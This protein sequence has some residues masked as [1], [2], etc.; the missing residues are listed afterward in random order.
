MIWI[1][2]NSSK[3]SEK[4][5]FLEQ[6]R[7]SFISFNTV[8][9]AHNINLLFYNENK[10]LMKHQRKFLQHFFF[11]CENRICYVKSF[12]LAGCTEQ[13]TSLSRGHPGSVQEILG[14]KLL[15][16]EH[17]VLAAFGKTADNNKCD[18]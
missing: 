14:T 13:H 8:Y 1:E 10:F 11:L 17:S 16:K 9:S 12:S 6:Q 3:F 7:F 2:F 5:Y 18:I 4:S 15:L